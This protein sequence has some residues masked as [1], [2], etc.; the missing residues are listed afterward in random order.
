MEDLPCSGRPETA[1]DD[2]HVQQVAALLQEDRCQTCEQ[3]G[4]QLGISSATLFTRSLLDKLEKKKLFAKWVPHLLSEEQKATRMQL[5]RQHLRRFR[6]EGED[7]LSR[8]FVTGD[9]KWVFSWD[10][11]TEAHGFLLV[12]GQQHMKL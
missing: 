9:E 5:T 6:R 12:N 8:N 7:F 4:G 10:L 1:S 2:A 11:N 3:L